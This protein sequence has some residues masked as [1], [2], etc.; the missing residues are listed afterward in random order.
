M[1]N[2]RAAI[3]LQVIVPKTVAYLIE[4]RGYYYF[5]PAI[6]ELN[7]AGDSVFNSEVAVGKSLAIR[8]FDY[9]GQFPGI[10]YFTGIAGRH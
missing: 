10:I 2:I 8:P 9:S 7:C 4:F 5:R 1:L 3:E 6:M